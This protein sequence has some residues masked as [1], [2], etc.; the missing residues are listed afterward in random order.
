MCIRTIRMFRFTRHEI[1]RYAICAFL[2]SIELLFSHTYVCITFLIMYGT[3]W[4]LDMRF[5]TRFFAVASCMLSHVDNS[6]LNFGTGIH[7]LVDY[8]TAA[9]RIQV[10]FT[11]F[12]TILLR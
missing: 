8:L 11:S 2:D 10:C 9:K 4:S 5:D 12:K 6:L 3:M 7:S 1:I